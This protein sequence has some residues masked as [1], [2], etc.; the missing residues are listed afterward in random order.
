MLSLH[1]YNSPSKDE[2]KFKTFSTINRLMDCTIKLLSKRPRQGAF[3]YTIVMIFKT[4]RNKL[5]ILAL[6]IIV[7]LLA[8]LLILFMNYSPN[9]T[10]NN[11]PEANETKPASDKN[12][13]KPTDSATENKQK[14]SE[15]QLEK[16][17]KS[18]QKQE[19]SVENLHGVAIGARHKLDIKPQL[20]QKWYFCA[21]AAVSMILSARNIVADQVMLAQEMGTYEPFGTHNRDAIKVLNKHMFGYELPQAGQ[22]GYRLETVKAVDQK[23]I[24]LFKQ[25]LIKNTKDGYPMYYTINPAKI[26]PGVNNS[27]HNVAGAGYIATPDGTDVALIY[28]IDPYPNFQDPVYGGLKVV[29]PEELL[30]ATVGVSEPNYAW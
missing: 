19:D 8:S 18:T 30:Q 15:N 4:K 23:T 28:Y 6:I 21:P 16:S 14:P 25:R 1:I 13:K 11:H 10:K 24:E 12:S 22:A 20:Q 9:T 27:E 26:Y 3:C 2:T 17:P 29:T 7:A 5:T